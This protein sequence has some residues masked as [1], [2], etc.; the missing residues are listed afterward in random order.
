[1]FDDS[2]SKSWSNNGAYMGV[3]I[4]WGMQNRMQQQELEEKKKKNCYWNWESPEM[5]ICIIYI[6]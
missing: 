5:Q 1:M 4:V 2:S 6:F 3:I